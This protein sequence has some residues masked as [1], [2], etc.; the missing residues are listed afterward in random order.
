MGFGWRLSRWDGRV[1]I[2]HDGDT[3]G[4]SAYLRVDP[5]A[6]VAACLLTNSA[7]SVTLYRQVFGEVF[8]DL[9]G[10][11]LPA[12]R[13]PGRPAADPGGHRGL[14]TSTP[15]ATSGR[16]GGSTSRSATGGCTWS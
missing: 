4:Q 3:I 6:R 7:E 8:A 14:S 2:G 16:H 5:E 11:A 9:T 15:A 1:V 10:A 12:D 13:R